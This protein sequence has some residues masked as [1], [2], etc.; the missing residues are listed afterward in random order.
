MRHELGHI[1]SR[2]LTNRIRFLSEQDR[3]R[4]T[5]GLQSQEMN[6]NAEA[7]CN[8][9]GYTHV[10]VACDDDSICDCMISGEINEVGDEQKIHTL[11]LPRIVY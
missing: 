8:L 10:T 4:C 11:L 2:Y 6:P 1:S 7:L 3:L 9:H 5:A